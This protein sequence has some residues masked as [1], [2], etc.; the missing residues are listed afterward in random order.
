[1]NMLM[2]FLGN[3]ALNIA[4]GA[5]EVFGASVRSRGDDEFVEA[6]IVSFLI[7]CVYLLFWLKNKGQ[8]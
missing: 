5:M 1:M 7:V 8:Y 4:S 2:E 3:F 6:L